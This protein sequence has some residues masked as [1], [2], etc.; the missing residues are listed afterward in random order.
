MLNLARLSIHQILLTMRYSIFNLAL[1]A[2]FATAAPKTTYNSTVQE[3]TRTLDEIHKAALAEGGVV[4]VWHGG[5]ESTTQDALKKAFEA[6]F[7][8]MH[9][10]I[11]VD[12]SKY[13]DGNL[14]QQ[15]AANNFTVDSI[16]LQTLHDFPRWK[17]QG[18]LLN[19]AP[20]GFG[21]VHSPFKDKDAA[22]TG[23]FVTA[24]GMTVNLN[25]TNTTVKEYTDFL[26]PVFKDKLALTYPND[27]D[28]ILYQFHLM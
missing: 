24:W 1:L 14:D 9:L 16:I 28:A 18:A 3:E 23:L 20:A 13:H 12:L 15:I 19:Y 11:T 21:K 8:G 2:A 7:P 6:R 10:N 26:K 4:T 25:K 27:D 22:Y 17:K 5:D